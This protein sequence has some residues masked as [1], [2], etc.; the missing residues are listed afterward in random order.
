MSW[1]RRISKIWGVVWSDALDDLELILEGLDAIA[2]E[3]AARHRD[4]DREKRQIVQ[5]LERRIRNG[6]DSASG[7]SSRVE[8]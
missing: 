4:Q 2:L 1:T 6:R 5:D 3:L 7:P 8:S